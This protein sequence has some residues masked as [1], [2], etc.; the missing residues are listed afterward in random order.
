ML[1][2]ADADVQVSWVFINFIYNIQW[3]KISQIPVVSINL[4]AF[5]GEGD[6]LKPRAREEGL[7]VLE[8]PLSSQSGSWELNACLSL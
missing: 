3:S 1:G 2:D 6:K 7:S 4:S 8:F 5:E